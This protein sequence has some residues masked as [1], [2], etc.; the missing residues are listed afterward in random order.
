MSDL[1]TEER[2]VEPVA[3]I[4]LTDAASI[5]PLIHTIRGRQVML[6]SDLARLY[7][8][9]TKSLNRAAT[10]NAD[11]FPEDSASG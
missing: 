3:Q 5:E 4:A 9:E 11:R 6:D 8:V 7:E 1:D 10:R 2:S